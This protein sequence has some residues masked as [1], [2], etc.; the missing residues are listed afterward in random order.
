MFQPV[1]KWSGSKRTQAEQLVKLFPNF[2]TY[3][4]P[5]LG[6]GSVLYLLENRLNSAVCGDICKPL[7][8]LWILIQNDPIKLIESYKEN[9]TRLQKEGYTVVVYDRV[10]S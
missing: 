2:K 6:G 8:E 10:N 5:F 9:W 7:I 4:E 3:Y 1:I